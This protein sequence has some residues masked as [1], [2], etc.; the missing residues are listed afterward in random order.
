[1]KKILLLIYISLIIFIPLKVSALEI[2]NTEIIGTTEKMIGEEFIIDYKINFNDIEKNKTEGIWFLQY[3]L[4]FDEETLLISEIT[5]NDFET[6]IY[7]ENDKYYVISEVIETN[8]GENICNN[9]ILYCGNYQSTIKFYIKNTEKTE[10]SIKIKDIQVALL[11]IT[12]ETK[13]Y[14][15]DDITE[16]TN[17]DEKNHTIKINKTSNEIKEEPKNIVTD[18]KPIIKEEK[19]NININKENNNSSSAFIKELKIK[20]YKINFDKNKTNYNITIEKDINE[21]DIDIKLENENATYKII[22]ADDLKSNNNE[23]AIIVTSEDNNI[24]TYTI[25]IKY[26]DI[27]TET[28]NQKKLDIKHLINKYLTKDNLTYAVIT[29]GIIIIIILLFILK[30]KRENKKINKLLGEL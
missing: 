12:D 19:N 15:I 24:I 26:D 23:V 8:N 6:Y 18:N 4:I 30:N 27:I 21:L 2:T 22:G 29:I 5:S 9:G 10:T 16:L 1:M 7:K 11:D 3:E 20:N 25:N 28:N 17:T 14:T 13:K